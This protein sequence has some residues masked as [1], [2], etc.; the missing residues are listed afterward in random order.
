MLEGF[1]TELVRLRVKTP[2]GL[3]R[4]ARKHWRKD[5]LLNLL[6]L[7]GPDCD[8]FWRSVLAPPRLEPDDGLLRL[9]DELREIFKRQA[10]DFYIPQTLNRWLRW[11]PEGS[12]PL[13][14]YILNWPVLDDNPSNL[15]VS[16]VKAVTEV[17]GHI[18]RCENP[19]CQTYFVKLK[20]KYRFCDSRNCQAYGQ[21]KCKREWWAKEGT[22]RRKLSKKQRSKV[23]RSN[24]AQPRART[25]H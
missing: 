16:L 10:N 5:L 15:R 19:D 8:P 3:R 11:M 23:S 21:R 22:A 24:R 7:Q 12:V 18:G 4:H 2:V 6:N 25:K 17:Y 14:S 9:R 1:G 20:N 13:P